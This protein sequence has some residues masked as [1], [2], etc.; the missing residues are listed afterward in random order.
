MLTVSDYSKRDIQN[1]LDL[2]GKPV[3]V[4][5]QAISPQFNLGQGRVL[6]EPVR[7]KLALPEHFILWVGSV[8]PRKRI[9]ELIDSF[10]LLADK[11]GDVGLVICGRRLFP[12][13]DA[14][15]HAAE[16]GNIIQRQPKPSARMPLKPS[17]PQLVVPR[18]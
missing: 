3:H 14:E 10:G 9:Y 18:S 15:T 6:A 17:Q 16:R 2:G 11:R 5:Y 7:R 4:A 1:T 12:D 13:Y 8:E